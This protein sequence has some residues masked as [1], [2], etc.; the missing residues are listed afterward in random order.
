[1]A[2]RI[3][4]A[5]LSLLA[6]LLSAMLQP[7]QASMCKI[8]YRSYFDFKSVDF[9]GMPNYAFDLQHTLYYRLCTNYNST[10]AS[11]CGGEERYMGNLVLLDNSSSIQ[12]QCRDLASIEKSSS[13]SEWQ[14]E[15]HQWLEE[16]YKKPNT[17]TKFTGR[18]LNNT[19]GTAITYTKTTAD[20]Y[21]N[22]QGIN[23]FAFGLICNFSRPADKAIYKHE[24]INGTLWFFYEG[25]QACGFKMIEPSV[26]LKNHLI[27]PITF[28]ILSISGMIMR[29][30]SERI[31]MTMFG[32][33]FGMFITV[34]FMANL[35]L[36]FHYET[37]TTAA[38]F[39]CSLL[40][41]AFFGFVC[42]SSRNI[43]ILVLFLGA[44]LSMSYTLLSILV[45]AT[46]KGISVQLFVSTVGG[47]VVL[48]AI[49][50][51]IP[52]FYDKYANLYLVSMDFPFYTAMSISVIVGWYPVL[53]TISRAQEL[54]I[55]LLPRK[56]HWWFI[57][58]QILLSIMLIIDS[59][60][61][62]KQMHYEENKNDSHRKS[63]LNESDSQDRSM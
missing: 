19:S 26:F 49:L 54:S 7:S 21:I 10:L 4:T 20:K 62:A 55:N 53:L 57:G 60:F 15:Y 30:Y 25:I 29:R 41:G 23:K 27:F 50:N 43:S 1:M 40:I 3:S 46:E 16:Y 35:E 47:L 39:I 33:E 56:E 24:K 11:K 14:L 12:P 42:F 17:L 9:D 18:L 36:S 32:V 31:M 34:L 48:M 58:L 59:K 22:S 61:V 13:K 5:R 45:M 2:T 44:A 52:S 6:T 51:N 8:L 28:L 63:F 38:V 37:A